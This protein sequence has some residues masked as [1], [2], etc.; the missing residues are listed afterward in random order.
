MVHDASGANGVGL[1]VS[2]CEIWFAGG[3]RVG[4]AGG[5]VRA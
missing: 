1:W 3:T 4:G 5:E 2:V